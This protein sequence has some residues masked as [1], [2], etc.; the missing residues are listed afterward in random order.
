MLVL[1]ASDLD[2]IDILQGKLSSFIIY[3]AQELEKL[4]KDSGEDGTVVGLAAVPCQ[5][6]K[7][8][9]KQ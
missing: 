2:G 7:P 4:E 3:V 6:S 1:A 5:G 9:H 8:A